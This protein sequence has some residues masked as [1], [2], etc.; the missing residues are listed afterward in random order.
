M[1]VKKILQDNDITPTLQRIVILNYLMS[2]S[3]HPTADQIFNDINQDQNVTISKATVY[4]TLNYFIE[5]NLVI[6]VMTSKCTQPHYDYFLKPH[7]HLICSKCGKII[8]ANYD[9]FNNDLNHMVL[10][11]QKNEFKVSNESINLY[12]VCKT[13]LE[14]D[15]EDSGN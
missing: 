7:F 6:K 15:E 13:C 14:N 3:K 9:N 4:N 12:G 10:E 8:D 2:S 1:N 5:K 11:A